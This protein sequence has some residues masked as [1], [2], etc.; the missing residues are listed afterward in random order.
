MKYLLLHQSNHIWK[1]LQ[2][3]NFEK[4]NSD[5]VRETNIIYFW[6]RNLK[7][8]KEGN[9]NFNKTGLLIFD[10]NKN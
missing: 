3:F 5:F 4:I 10:S 6:E 2:N 1:Y 8:R 9:I 7:L